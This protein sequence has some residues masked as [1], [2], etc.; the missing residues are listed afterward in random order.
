MTEQKPFDGNRYSIIAW[1]ND[2]DVVYYV[3]FGSYQGEWLLVSRDADNYYVY[4]DY[5]GSCSGCDNY[6]GSFGNRPNKAEAQE[7]AKDYPP[8]V[9]VPRE[10]M[11]ALAASEGIEPILPFNIRDTSGDISWEEALA[12][13]TA[14]VKII[15]ALPMTADDVLACRNAEVK[16]KALKYLGYEKFVE[17]KKPDL[18]DARGDDQL[19]K[20]DDIVMLHVKDASTPRRYL[21]RVPPQTKTVLAGVAWT[22]GKR[23]AEYHPL[24]ET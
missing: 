15:E 8:F 6:E 9:R 18:L 19:L 11:R 21:L 22:F 20:I 5:Y 3:E 16:Q 12:D 23:E 17:Q 2:Q 1:A 4:K 10:T 13:I 14:G 24:I 7:F